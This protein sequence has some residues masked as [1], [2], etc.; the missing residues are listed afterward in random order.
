MSG[1]N[2]TQGF[3]DNAG[4]AYF[5]VFLI[6]CGFNTNIPACMTYQVL[7]SPCPSPVFKGGE[8]HGSKGYTQSERTRR[9]NTNQ[10]NNIRG[11][12]KRAFCSATLIGTGGIGGIA[13]SLMF[14][15]QDAPAYRPGMYASLGCAGLT[16]V[17]ICIN[18]WYFKRENAKADKGLKVLQGHP[19]FRY[20]V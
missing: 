10:S 7:R 17:V 8:K 18:T 20:T 12:W 3:V 5:G 9:A 13:G 2:S 4:V 1:T 14:R 19:D 16:L 6:C 11:Q 15:S